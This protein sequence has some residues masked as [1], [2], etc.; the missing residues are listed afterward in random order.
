MMI[1]VP[2]FYCSHGGCEMGLSG[3]DWY[4]DSIKDEDKK[5]KKGLDFHLLI[6]QI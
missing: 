3:K 4:R 6:I 1:I 5:S 2:S